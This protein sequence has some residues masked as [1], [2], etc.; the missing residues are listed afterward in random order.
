MEREL[1]SGLLAAAQS[2]IAVNGRIVEQRA[3]GMADETSRFFIFSATKTLT[4]TALLPHLADRSVDLTAPVARYVPAFGANG[5]ADVTVLQLLTMQGGFPQAVMSR[6]KWGSRAER[7]E[8]FAEWTLEH[9]AG[10][11]TEYHPASAHWVIAELIDSVGSI[12]YVDAVHDRVVAPAGA[13]PI[14]GDG[15]L[16]LGPPTTIRVVGTYPDDPATLVAAYGRA[17]LV[18]VPSITPEGILTMNDPRS[19]KAAIPGGGGISTAVDMAMIYQHLVHNYHG[20]L[21]DDWLSDSVSTI[22]NVSVSASDKV[23]ANR[24]TTGYVSG[25][26][27]YHLHRWMPAAPRAFGHAGAGGQLCW[28]DPDS[29]VSF[30]FL[31]DTIS[32]DPT[33]EFRR[34]AD[35]N[36]L[37]LA[38]TGA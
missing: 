16:A 7:C 1:D 34:A 27:G 13:A 10:S 29:G 37:V 28:V 18:P 19:W 15:A 30:A 5:K 8:Q 32:A 25:A 9:P 31:H 38:A 6:R 35:L 22:R 23:P 24:T 14:L 26:D 33:V 20:A 3:Y 2:A 11:R 36:A 17:D 4:A 21:P 12:S